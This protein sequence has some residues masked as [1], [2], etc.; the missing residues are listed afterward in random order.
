MTAV[1]DPPFNDLQ[2]ALFET[3]DG[4]LTVNVYDQVPEPVRGS[5]VTIGEAVGTPDNWHGGFGWDIVISVHAWTSEKPGFKTALGVAQDVIA[6][7]DHQ[8]NELVLDASTWY[9]VSMRFVQLQ[10]LRDPDPRIRHVPV[11]F[12][13]VIHQLEV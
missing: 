3:L 10:T 8:L 7:I 1:A 11:Q 4:A 13:A 5:W 6:L 2:R 9:V 12:R